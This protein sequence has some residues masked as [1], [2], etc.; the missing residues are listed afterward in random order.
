MMRR[1]MAAILL[2]SAAP[3]H[4]LDEYLQA[5]LFSV[6]KQRVEAQIR[7][8][9]GVAVLPAVLASID[10]DAD[11]TISA[12]EQRSYAQKVRGDLSLSIDGDRLPLELV[13]IQF[14]KIEQMKEGLGEIR[15]DLRAQ[16]PSGG[17]RRS[18]AF[19]NRHQSGIAV[20]LV[21]ALAP[22][23]PDIRI[24]AQ[25]RNTDQSV[26]ELQYVQGGGSSSYLPWIVGSVLLLTARL[27]WLGRRRS[28]RLLV[29][30]DLAR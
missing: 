19:Q 16:L 23:D 29:T 9:P 12:A 17:A 14:P 10:S 11:G 6:E 13:S 1:L 26:Y 7:L 5:T 28:S 15:L 21:N 3:A 2:A 25:Q 27:V 4:R 18:L 20:Y 22:G 8:T 30:R 24:T